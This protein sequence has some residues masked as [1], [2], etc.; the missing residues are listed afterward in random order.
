MPS[1]CCYNIDTT[2][3]ADILIVGQIDALRD[4]SCR[5]VSYFVSAAPEIPRVTSIIIVDEKW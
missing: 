5:G 2:R 1:D 4:F 3:P